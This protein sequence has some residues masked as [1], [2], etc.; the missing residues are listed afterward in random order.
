M[1]SSSS[2]SRGQGILAPA[3]FLAL[4]LLFSW[5][6]VL[7]LSREIPASGQPV[8]PQHILYGLNWGATALLEN[9]LDYFHA[10]FFFPYSHSMAFL[11]QMFSLA[12]LA[13]PVLLATGNWVASYNVTWI[14]TFALSGWGAFLLTRH[15]TESTPAAYLAG[16]LY[17]F[18][19]FRYHSAGILHVVGMMWIPFALLMLH[20][21][22]QTE[23][24]GY[25]FAF[26]AFSLAQ[27]LASGYT[28]AFL[29][30]AAGLYLIVLLVLSRDAVRGLLR[31][32][33]RTLILVVAL[34]VV[35]LLPFL[36]PALRSV[37]GDPAHRRS[38]GET[39]LWSALPADFLTPAPGSLFRRLAPFAGAARQPLFSGWVAS[40]LVAAW[41]LTRGWRGHPRRVE[42]VFYLVLLG[43][44]ALL[45]LGPFLTVLGFRIP[46]PF[47]VVFY[48]LPGAAF[49]RS[50]VRFFILSSLAVAVLA[51][52]AV[53]R[54]P[55][56]RARKTGLVATL[57]AGGEL[58]AL[59]L[60]L[61]DPLPGGVPDVYRRLAESE[62]PVA[63][64]EL[65][66]PA[67]EAEET[68]AAA[69][70]QLYSLYHRKRLVNGVGAFVPA[71]TRE[72]RREMQGFPSDGAV[73]RLR[74]LGVDYVFVHSDA[75]P[76]EA[77]VRIRTAVASRGDLRVIEE[78]D[79][80]WVIEV[81]S[82]GPGSDTGS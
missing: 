62:E 6:L 22:V 9:P 54:L 44:G 64:L 80:V 36:W 34:G 37:V 68:V 75:Y 49:I 5:P 46:M 23:R 61:F 3:L 7:R 16:I 48:V 66:M 63:I 31:R 78:T 70:Y 12:L 27:F 52:A 59:P 21:W 13:A 41:I 81:V 29:I 20:R 30:L 65:P 73:I 28:G 74:N 50:P 39:A 33:W 60:L 15:L 76:P 45:A 8:D 17:A 55:R 43:V 38:L 11:D 77:A 57:L 72:V 71:I 82:H 40:F 58:L 1:T 25:L 18:H 67:S 69:R 35:L 4:A 53:G 26:L 14:L 79:T 19:P 10:T 24:S 32:R 42:L 56:A 51:G 47:A 2:P